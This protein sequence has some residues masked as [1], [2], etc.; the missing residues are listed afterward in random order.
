MAESNRGTYSYSL[1]VA[2]WVATA[3]LHLNRGVDETFSTRDIREMIKEQKIGSINDGS[4]DN[5][6]TTYC[7]ANHPA[8]AG[9]KHRKLYKIEETR[10]YRLYRDGDDYNDAREGGQAEPDDDEL[11]SNYQHLGKWYR[12][13]Y[14]RSTAASTRGRSSSVL[15]A[16]PDSHA[17]AGPR[18]GSDPAVPND[19]LPGRIL[20]DTGD[21]DGVA[22]SEPPVQA[23]R[24]AAP[25]L[26]SGES[27]RRY[28]VFISYAHKDGRDVAAQL[29]AGLVDRG[30]T[31]WRDKSQMQIGSTICDEIKDGLDNSRY[32]IV[33]ITPAYYERRNTLM[34]LGGI[35]FGD[36]KGKIIVILHKTSR[37]DVAQKLPAL[38]D[39]IM[40]CWNDERESL[41][42]VIA[43]TVKGTESQ[44]SHAKPGDATDRKLVGKASRGAA[45]GVPRTINNTTLRRDREVAAV[46]GLL[47]SN[48]RVAITGDKGSGKSVLSC[49]LY[50]ELA[51]HGTALL[52]RCDDFLG[53]ESAEELDRAIVPGRSLVGLAGRHS[54]STA[55]G[56]TVIF[57]SLDVAGRSEGTVRAFKRLIEQ[58]WGAGART[59]VTVRSYDYNYSR[60]LGATDW[61]EKYEL[62]PLFDAELDGILDA[63]GSPRVPARLRGLLANPLN[64]SLYALILNRS[65][66]ANLE[67]IRHEIDLYDAHWHHYVDTE[68]LGLR[69]KNV[70][71]AVAEDMSKARKTM[72]PYEPDDQ[73]AANAALSASILLRAGSGGLIRY[74]HHAYMD[75]AMSRALLER[76]QPIE[77]YLRADE[78]NVFLRPTLSMALAMAHERDAD[79]FAS[80]VMGVARADVKHHWK[81]V[82]A[83]ALADAAHDEECGAC[84]N[85]AGMLSE[86]PI[87]QRYFLMALAERQ[88]ASWFCVWGEAIA[89][90]AADPDNSN[91][92]FIIGCLEAAAAADARHHGHVFA[93]ARA[94]AERSGSGRVRKRAISMLASVDAKGKAAWLK[95]MS[96]SADPLVRLGVAHNL[97]RLLDAEPGAIPDIFCALY[98]HE[99]A[100]VREK[101]AGSFGTLRARSAAAQDND[102][103]RWKLGKMLPDLMEASMPAMLRAAILTAER[104][105]RRAAPEA[106]DDPAGGPLVDWPGHAELSGGADP[107]LDAAKRHVAACGDEAFVRLASLLEGTRL[108]PFRRMLIDGMAKRAPMFANKIAALLS[109]P[110]TYNP[111]GLR[112]S[113]RSALRQVVP[114]LSGPQAARVYEAIAASNT[115]RDNTDGGLLQSERARAAFLSELP[116][117]LLSPEDRHMVDRHSRP[118]LEGG[119]PTAP[120]P[121]RDTPA[122]GPGQEPLMT[123]KG[124]LGGDLDRGKKITLLGSMLNLLTGE[125][126]AG[127]DG[128]L[129]SEMEAFLLRNKGDSGPAQDDVA[130]PGSSR[131]TAQSV[132]GLVAECLIAILPHRKGEGIL[133]A[134]REL[135]DDPADLVRSSVARSLPRLLPAHHD[136][137][138]AIAM[139]YRLDPDPRVRSLLPA[140]LY[141]ILRQD[142]ASASSTIEDILAA[143]SKA[144]EST[145]LLMLNLAVALK[146]PHATRAL[147]RIADEGA[148]DKELRMHIPYVLKNGFLGTEHQDAALDL[149]YRMLHDPLREVRHRAAF[150]TLNGFDDNP[151]IDNR[152]YIAKIA[153]HLARITVMLEGPAFDLS[154]AEIL[155]DFFG[156]F[157]KEAPAAALAYLERAVK[158]HGPAVASDPPVAESSLNAL[159][160][161][162]QHHSLYDSEWNRCIDVLDAFAAAGWPAAL[163]LLSE[164][165]SRD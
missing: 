148:F 35:V 133:E 165:G 32:A 17:P 160:G 158:E 59:V 12:D 58:V 143:S 108:V 66:G 92:L 159:A 88:D 117:A 75:Y 129:L 138:R 15:N 145:A 139:S 85:L 109:D 98:T 97:P 121:I 21:D 24:P 57:D 10:R 110:Q 7:V 90:W 26:K 62:G 28:D 31:V 9:Y 52:V 112:R 162:L 127:L 48:R 122:E 156:K 8:S 63:I 104:M 154:A 137:A 111:Y 126:G 2:V 107:L 116:R 77:A 147:D 43:D 87:L 140:A 73:E 60:A 153:P 135:S 50:E 164:M 152:E 71:Y 54:L 22:P 16:A 3:T 79:E 114:L 36:Y 96:D 149:L 20:H 11:P 70:L 56:M 118:A 146:E 113:V 119:P 19:E 91:G 124:L 5:N 44:A 1:P 106:W 161:L 6:I 18:V 93:A 51:K 55:G 105:S 81:I 102:M 103:I 141:R 69:V 86:S 33:V 89:S 40:S 142:P 53:T 27:N 128:D 37:E 100:P 80:I 78:Y 123:V 94:L 83:A 132:R 125:G 95:T 46:R 23:D 38:A 47:E 39:N 134:I 25:L 101:E 68:P 150:F 67:S 151:D 120:G 64:L 4:I 84:A 49:L 74:F 76:H 130:R 45:M 61:G 13:E 14:C 163:E 72:V 82:A 131:A 30:L 144:P 41:M 65:P 34:E 99:E 42:N 155:A 157:W 115:P 136:T 29:D